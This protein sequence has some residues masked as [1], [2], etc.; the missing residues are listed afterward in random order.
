MNL[1]KRV[2]TSVEGKGF[3]KPGLEEKLPNSKQIKNY[4]SHYAFNRPTNYA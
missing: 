1:M 2:R 4:P 3:M